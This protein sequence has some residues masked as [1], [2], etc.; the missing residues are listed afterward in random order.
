MISALKKT[1]IQTVKDMVDM[2][3][4]TV[5]Q[6]KAELDVIDE[7]YRKQ[8]EEE[9]KTLKTTL[10]E[11]KAQLKVWEKLFSSFDSTMVQEALGYE[12][13]ATVEEEEQP[14]VEQTATVEEAEPI[15]T[16]T[17]FPE[18]NEPEEV[19]EP[20][21]VD[22]H[23]GESAGDP[24]PDEP[25]PAPQNLD[26]AEDAE[27]DQRI[28]SGELKPVEWPEEHPAEKK[29]VPVLVDGDDGWPMPEDWK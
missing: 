4:D 28:E 13:T 16:D 22:E 23:A 7:K 10:A 20:A 11:A 27:W 14:T 6:A 3:K 17:I 15:V 29:E 12:A 26:A 19:V 21:P 24:V 18:N 25:A 1:E 5:E 9:K 8:I 2:F